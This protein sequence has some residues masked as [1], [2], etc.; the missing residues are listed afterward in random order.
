M[1]LVRNFLKIHLEQPL[2]YR[3]TYQLFHFIFLIFKIFLGLHPQHIE[4]PR[5][6]VKLEL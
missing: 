3:L 5:L 1:C 4:V 2:G 6:G